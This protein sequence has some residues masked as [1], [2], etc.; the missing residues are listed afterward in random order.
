MKSDG[1]KREELKGKKPARMLGSWSLLYMSFLTSHKNLFITCW[2]CDVWEHL[3]LLRNVQMKCYYFSSEFMNASRF[4]R[5]SPNPFS[6][7]TSS[8]FGLSPQIVSGVEGWEA[9]TVARLFSHRLSPQFNISPG[10]AAFCVML[11]TTNSDKSLSPSTDSTV[12]TNNL[13]WFVLI[14]ILETIPLRPNGVNKG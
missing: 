9:M 13:T 1:D 14:A 11:K 10:A 8:V 6:I 4:L 7:F 2:W 5:L 3:N 12:T